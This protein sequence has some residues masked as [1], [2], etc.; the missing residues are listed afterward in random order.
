[1]VFAGGGMR[2][3]I[4]LGMYAAACD[5]GRKPDVLL[6]SCGGALAAAIVQGLPDDARRKA[7]LASPAMHAFWRDLQPGPQAGIARLVVR[8]TRRR[9]ARQRAPRVPDLFGDYLFEAPMHLPL[10]SG[11]AADAP[12]VAVIGGRLLFGEAEV[13]RPRGGRPLFEET[14]FGDARTAAL[15]QGMASPFA[16]PCWGDHAVAG[17]VAADVAM[18]L[19]VACRLSIADFFYFRCVAH[20]GRHYIGGVVDLFPIE[21]A[22]RLAD[23]VVMEFKQPFDQGL[24]IPAWRA[25]LG[26]DGNQRLRHVHAQ[27]VA[28][29]ID[30]SDIR[31]VL[32]RQQVHRR[33]DWHRNR[34]GLAV[35]PDPATYARHI[36]D[37]WQYGYA[38]AAEALRRP[39]G[40]ARA[41]RKVDRFNQGQPCAY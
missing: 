36:E 33:I 3:G 10:P 14:V 7:W 27:Q 21:V 37:Q 6:A 35:P 40:D 5:A 11:A 16:A 32:A 8:A 29:W 34:V 2:F 9:F 20:A 28:A 30:S 41:M 1:M 26:L 18:P 15:L 17:T 25:V 31:S 24:S 13:G 4:Y 39:A 19:D 22:R 38:R 23:E 12:A